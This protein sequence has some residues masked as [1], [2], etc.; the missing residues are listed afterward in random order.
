MGRVIEVATGQSLDAYLQE[1]VFGPL[2]M[3]ETGFTVPAG[4]ESRLPTLYAPGPDGA[5]VPVPTSVCGDYGPAQ[6]LFSG[7]GGLVSTV[8][9][10]LRFAQMLLNGG[11]LDGQRVLSTGSAAA[12][13]QNQLDPALL[14]LPSAAAVLG[15]LD[16]PGQGHGFGGGVLLDADATAIPDAPGVYRWMGY[17]FTFF[18]IDPNE[19]LIGIVMAQYVPFVPPT[20][21][22]E[23]EVEAV[24]YGALTPGR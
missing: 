16:R 3:T 20:T 7:G 22:I 17:A 24:I 5:L 2:G 15:A 8:A 6:R 13:M 4:A 18:W 19:E 1:H 14:P 21:S 10:Y 23:K 11:E 12:I 9:D